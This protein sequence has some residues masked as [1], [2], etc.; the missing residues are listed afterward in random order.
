LIVHRDIEPANIFITCRGGAKLLDFGLANFV[1]SPTAETADDPTA[2]AHELTTRG[3]LIGTV[4]YMSPEQARGLPANSQSDPFS[5]GAVLY[6][7]A[8]SCRAFHGNFAA[9]I[10]VAI[11]ESTPIAPSRLNPPHL[12]GSTPALPTLASL[13]ILTTCAT[14]PNSSLCSAT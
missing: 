1:S 8:T 13:N 14:H 4:A 3:I 9:E 6:E 2:T 7:M 11:L 5:L 12:S 10:F